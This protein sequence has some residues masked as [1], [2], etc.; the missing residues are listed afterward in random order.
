MPQPPK[1]AKD[2]FLAALDA[3]PAARIVLLDD[4]CAGDVELRRQVEALLQVHDEP[5]SLLDGPRIDLGLSAETGVLNDIPTIDQPII[6]ALGTVIGPYKLLQEI[7][8]GGM[9][10]VYMAE[11][12]EPV[13]RRGG[14]EDHQAGDGHPAGGRPL[15]GRAAGLGHDGPPEHRPCAGRGSDR[16]GPTLLRDGAGHGRPHHGSIATRTTSARAS[17]WSCSS[18]LPG[19]PARSSEGDHPPGSQAVQHPGHASG[20]P[21]G[22]QDHRFRHRQGHQQATDRGNDVHPRRPDRGHAAVHE[23]RAGRIERGGRGHAI[24]HLLAGSAAVRTA[25]RLSRR[26]TKS[27]CAKPD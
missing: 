6:E 1:T 18:G 27:G 19:R 22:A 11:Q 26:S 5:D 20:R 14:P 15:R 23:P 4:L 24:G 21:A 10:V 25:H 7:G 2:I 13:E 3:D 16:V 8:E 9:G 12:R 17:G